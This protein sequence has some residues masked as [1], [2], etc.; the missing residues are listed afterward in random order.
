[1]FVCSPEEDLGIYHPPC[2]IYTKLF[3]MNKSKMKKTLARFKNFPKNSNNPNTYSYQHI[4]SLPCEDKDLELILF[5]PKFPLLNVNTLRFVFNC[6]GV[7]VIF[8]SSLLLLH[9]VI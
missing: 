4:C 7:L 8:L 5:L 2:H 6:H 1:M 9:S 3:L